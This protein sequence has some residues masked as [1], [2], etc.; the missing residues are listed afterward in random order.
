MKV[1]LIPEISY[2]V[3]TEN[4]VPLGVFTKQSEWEGMTKLV[5][6]MNELIVESQDKIF[7]MFSDGEE[8]RVAHLFNASPNL[9]E[10]LEKEETTETKT[11]IGEMEP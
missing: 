8:E 3:E 10:Q 9:I 6:G 5:S 11:K 7:R 2:R 1:K 4:G